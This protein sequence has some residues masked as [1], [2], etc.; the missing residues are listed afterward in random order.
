LGGFLGGFI[1][2]AQGQDVPDRDDGLTGSPGWDDG[3]NDSGGGG[4]DSGN[5]W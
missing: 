3:S 2:P 4:F 5:D 1:D